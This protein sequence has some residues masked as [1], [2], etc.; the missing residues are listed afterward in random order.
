M[1]ARVKAFFKAIEVSGVGK[2][3]EL[4]AADPELKKAQDPRNRGYCALD[5][6]AILGP[7]SQCLSALVTALLASECK[8]AVACMGNRALVRAG[9]SGSPEPIRILLAAGASSDGD[10]KTLNAL[11]WAANY[12]WIE[13]VKAL[14]EAGADV[15][16]KL[17]IDE[18]SQDGRS[19]LMMAAKSRCEGGGEV[20]KALIAAGA[21]LEARG[22]RGVSALSYAASLLDLGADI[23][24]KDELGLPPLAYF[25]EEESLP[26]GRNSFS[27]DGREECRELLE[28]RGLGA[29]NGSGAR[30]KSRR[31]RASS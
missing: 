16:V 17:P 28:A 22:A 26:H 7:R 3:G 29:A 2:T 27:E 19:A 5:I 10:G 18:H 14:V 31:G 23:M 24:A 21:D 12:G 6:E 30:A 13:N 15:N 25:Q 1:A 11:M 9:G 4:L 8:D 20:L